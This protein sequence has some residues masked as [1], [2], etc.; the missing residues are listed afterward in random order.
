MDIT[1]RDLRAKYSGTFT[2][3]YTQAHEENTQPLTSDLGLTLLYCKFDEG[4][5]FICFKLCLQYE[6]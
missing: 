5:Y 2:K 4:C 1:K 3:K 6:R